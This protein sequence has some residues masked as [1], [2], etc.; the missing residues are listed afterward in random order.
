MA[1]VINGYERQFEVIV[2]ATL[3]GSQ[4]ARAHNWLHVNLS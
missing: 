3:L 4:H 2:W 1:H